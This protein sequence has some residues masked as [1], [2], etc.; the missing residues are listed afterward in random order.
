MGRGVQKK[1]ITGVFNAFSY[2]YFLLNTFQ[3]EK[4]NCS[5]K[6]QEYV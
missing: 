5:F 6:K 1:L 2:C 4:I 3:I